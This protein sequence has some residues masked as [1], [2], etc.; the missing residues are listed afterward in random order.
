MRPVKLRVESDIELQVKL[1]FPLDTALLLQLSTLAQTHSRRSACLRT[2]DLK[3]HGLTP[4]L[5]IV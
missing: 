1:H 3:F 2:F 5:R 4:Q